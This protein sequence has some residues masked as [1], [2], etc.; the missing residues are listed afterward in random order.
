MLLNEQEWNKAWSVSFSPMSEGRLHLKY[1]DGEERV[2][3]VWDYLKRTI[4]TKGFWSYLFDQDYFNEVKSV[5]G[6]PDWGDGLINI[7]PEILYMESDSIN[8]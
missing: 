6:M 5:E 3:D 7:S 1:P 2:F 8:P 4:R